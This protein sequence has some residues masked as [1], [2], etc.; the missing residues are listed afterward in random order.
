MKKMIL[1][2]ASLST[3]LT[4][5]LFINEI[6]YDQP[7]TDAS[8]F[9]EISGPAGSYSNV[10]LV[11]INGN[12]NSEYD[13]YNLDTVSLNDESQGYGFYVIGTSSIPN[14]DFTSGFPSTNAIQNGD[15]D[16]IELWVNGELVDAVSYA[17]TMDD[18]A[19]G[20]MEE[21]TSNDS[22]DEFWEGDDGLSIGRLGVDSSPWSVMSNSPG[23]INQD[24]IFDPDADFAPT[25]NAGSNQSVQ[26]GDLVTLD[27]SAS[28]DSDG[29]II[30]YLWEQSSGPDVALSTDVGAVVTFTFP[31]VTET[32]EL[33][34]ELSVTDDGGNISSDEVNITVYMLT[35]V[36]IYDIQE[37]FGIY[38]GQIVSVVGVVT[39]GDGLL[40][41]SKT[42]FYI[43][44]E[45]GRGIQIY[46]DPPLEYVYNRGDYIEVTGTVTQYNDDVEITEPTITLLGTGSDLP[47]AHTVTGSEGLTMNGTWA[48]A[49]GTLSDY[50]YYQSG[51]SEFTALTITTSEGTEIQTMFWNSAVPSSELT[52][53]EDMVGEELSILG[54][55]TFYDGAVQLT[56]GYGIDIQSNLDP[57]LPV[58]DA[59]SDQSVSPGDIAT[60]DGSASSDS[61][62][63]IIA[64]EWVQIDGTAVVLDNEE[65]AITFFTA[66][67][68]IDII[69]FRLTVWDDEINES[70]DEVSITVTTSGPFTISEIINNCGEDMGES[71]TCDGQ[72]DLSTDSA[73]E[74][75][76]Y[77]TQVTTTGTIIDYFDITPFNGPHSFTIQDANGNQIDFVVWPESSEYQDGFDITQTSL[78]VLTET[79]F[80]VH[81]VTITGELG[82]YCD[83][84]ESLDINSE[85]QVTV[86]YESDITI[87]DPLSNEAIV[88]A[89]YTLF[90]N[91]PNPFNPQTMIKFEVLSLDHINISIFD[92]K[93]NL[94]LDLV[95]KSFAPG[96]YSIVWNGKGKNGESVPSGLYIYQYKSSM[97]IVTK[98]MLLVK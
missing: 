82:A 32:T 81:E 89:E 10:N 63:S 78:N 33:V 26:S 21:A 30:S 98:R 53:Y 18:S 70:T 39:I 77:E 67:N 50:W 59:G 19:G 90:Q 28:F 97:D 60:L 29:E 22:D 47:Q 17:G 57:T 83:D 84:D 86:E 92:L 74:C 15:P 13:S 5:Q 1:I 2:F 20:T 14:V 65:D 88:P 46:N 25:A 16:G 44:D 95:D 31:D 61:N 24:Q 35:Q 87:I 69:R 43:Q 80:G 64:Y 96:E 68:D 94:I 8:E 9:I 93:G 4:A 62:G 91:Y 75:P 12:N 36:D 37:N 51:S 40:Y 34:F 27:G 3:I 11:L 55:I 6:D 7:G 76:L 41:P 52:E 79:P 45:S 38:D 56:C 58:A 42:K 85:W 23:A 48:N 54:A 71:L 49:T 72:Y 66:P 73:G